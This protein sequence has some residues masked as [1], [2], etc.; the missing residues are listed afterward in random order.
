MPMSTRLRWS[1]SG[2][3][4]VS[5]VESSSACGAPLNGAMGTPEIPLTMRHW[6]STGFKGSSAD[7]GAVRKVSGDLGQNWSM[8]TPCGMYMNPSRTGGLA[9]FVP[10][11]AQ[12]MQSNSGRA[13]EAPRPLRHVRR[14]RRKL[15]GIGG[16]NLAVQ[17][18]IAGDDFHD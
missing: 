3:L 8:T 6:L 4:A 18:G 2:S 16:C 13:S 11:S 17:E 15:L 10:A 14:L 7:G 1:A 9:G 12:P 5:Q